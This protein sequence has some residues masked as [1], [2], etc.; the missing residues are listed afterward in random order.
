MSKKKTQEEFINELKLIQP[1]LEVIGEYK[2]SRTPILIKTKYGICYTSAGSL[3]YGYK[4]TTK[5]AVDKTEYFI[6]ECKEIHGD[7]Y[8]YNKVEY[9]NAHK[10]VKIVCSIHGDFLQKA[11]THLRGSGCPKCHGTNGWAKTNG[12]H[13]SDWEKAGLKSK[14]FTGF[15]MYIIKCYDD[16]ET[17]YK[18]GKTYRDVNKRFGCVAHLPYKYTIVEI[19]ES[20]A[21]NICELESSMKRKNKCNR[22]LPNLYF[23]GNCEC[24]NKI[25]YK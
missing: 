16:F 15:K 5:S 21:K 3:L 7:R 4:P 11:Q 10:K 22:Y 19:I 25:Q 14:K 2:T 6:N 20:T 13:Y 9:T 1:N 23:K 8:D 18:I 12:W 24:F 17:F